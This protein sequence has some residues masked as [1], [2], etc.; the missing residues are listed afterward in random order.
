MFPNAIGPHLENCN[1]F[2][3]GGQFNLTVSRD[4]A[5][6]DA[7]IAQQGGLCRS[8]PNSTARISP[9]TGISVL[10]DNIA[11]AAAHNSQARFPPPKCYP[12]TRDAILANMIQWIDE[13]V[14][15]NDS[16]RIFWLYGPAGAGKSAIA[17][18]ISE[19][20][21]QRLQLAASFFFARGQGR[22]GIVNHIIAT[23][24]YQL[25]N[26]VPGIRGAI[27][28][29]VARDPSVIGL[30]LDVQIE[31]LI[32]EPFLS[33]LS[34]SA[35]LS[36]HRYLVIIDGLD[37]C[38][39]DDNQAGLLLH[40]SDLLHNHNL[41]FTFFITSRQERHIRDS[42]RKNPRLSN[43][44]KEFELDPSEEDIRT[45]LVGSFCEMRKDHQALAS[46]T[47]PWPSQDDIMHLVYQSSGYFIYASTIIKFIGDKDM[48]PVESLKLVLSCVSSPFSALDDLYCQI[49]STVPIA[50]RTALLSIL[51]IIVISY[52]FDAT[53][54]K[55]DE[56]LGLHDGEVQLILRRVN[57][58][59]AGIDSVDDRIYFVHKSFHDFI[60]NKARS[61]VFYVNECLGHATMAQGFARQARINITPKLG[62][63]WTSHFQA[64]FAELDYTS[65]IED[66]RAITMETWIKH[67]G[68]DM[69]R[70][71][72]SLDLDIHFL[73]VIKYQFICVHISVSMELRSLGFLLSRPV[74]SSWKLSRSTK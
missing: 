3:I 34:Q 27:G 64:G 38:D 42:F 57:S 70:S 61:G 33:F 58:L 56:L 40:I 68:S 55:I 43:I 67:L 49:L 39:G 47:E 11:I 54:R 25:T 53:S 71:A 37:E 28:R 1:L 22:R 29:A 14:L 20:F 21:A 45:F 46:L 26:S 8:L 13:R 31:R 32:V 48:H 9:I 24:A 62:L 6:N 18:T 12:E 60:T 72:S 16:K 35:I 51:A 41:P 69:S 15:R 19:K 66:L 44:T 23:I 65:F 59:L 36:H 73:E 74:S 17:Q 50:R 4:G 30:S 10:S 63:C 2:D 52:T 7:L 5:S